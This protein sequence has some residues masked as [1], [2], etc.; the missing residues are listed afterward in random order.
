MTLPTIT[1]LPPAPARSDAPADFSTKAD[2]LLAAQPRF[3]SETNA[4]AEFNNQCAAS[5]GSSAT[6]AAQ[7]ATDAALAR[8]AAQS[9]ANFKGQWSSLSGSLALP[10]TVLHNQQIWSLLTNLADVAASEPGVTGDWLV[11]GGIDASKTADF[12]AARNGSYWLGTTLTVTLPDTS[13]PPPKG[14]FV[15][16]TKALGAEPTIQAGAGA[17]VI[18]TAK[19][20]SASVL[21]DLDAEVIFVFSGTDWE[22]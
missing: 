13:T 16:L 8:D 19:G 14:T 3:V 17:A 4:V 10:A 1:P 5:S 9:V 7:A 12:T 2:A 22:V 6:A 18:Q 20:S 11:M 21:F 15:R